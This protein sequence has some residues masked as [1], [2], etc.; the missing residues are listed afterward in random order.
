MLFTLCIFVLLGCQAKFLLLKPPLE[1]E[2]EV[3]LYLQPFPQEADRLKFK[4]EG[5]SALRSDGVEF[6]FSLSLSELRARDMKRQRLLGSVRLPPGSY[7]GLSLKT[8]EAF[9]KVEEGEATLLVAN[10]PAKIDFPFNV[11]RKRAVVISLVFK[12]GESITKGFS[13]SP[14]FSAFIPAKPITSVVGFVTNSGSNDITVFDKKSAQVVAVIPT[15]RTPMGMALDQRLRRAYVALSGEDRIDVIDVTATEAIDSIRLSMGDR[16]RELAITPDGK[17]LLSANTDSN[18]VSI[19]DLVSL[20]E[21]SKIRVGN[22]PNSV[23]MD[24]QGRRAYVFN[25][26]SNTISVIDVPSRALVTNI[27][28]DPSPLRGQFNRRGDRVYV[29]NEIYSYLTVIDPFSLS[30]VRRASVSMG[31]SAIKVDINTDLIYLGRRR[32]PVVEVYNPSTFFPVNSIRADGGVTYITIDNE[33][34]KLHMVS[35][36][37]NSLIISDLTSQK[38]VSELDVGEGPSW[39]TLMGER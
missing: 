5:I 12:Y 22:G 14:V 8:K 3:Y 27:S 13:F 4:I 24:P 26:P 21:V 35:P 28:T 38:V 20:T 23:L 9:L 29:I 39:V 33:E 11:I 10:T 15:G 25:T 16:P 34:R 1:Q 18:S 32:D 19:I 6:P 36:E 37:R 2:G 17:V 7:T 31:L 30:V